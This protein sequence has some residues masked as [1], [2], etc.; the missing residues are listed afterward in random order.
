[1]VLMMPIPALTIPFITSGRSLMDKANVT[2]IAIN[3]ATV[4]R[5]LNQ[6]GNQTD[7][8]PSQLAQLT[9]VINS[10]REHRGSFPPDNTPWLLSLLNH[11]WPESEII[12]LMP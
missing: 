1:M 2:F 7:I 3:S 10:L 4:R 6:F 5:W 9:R 12:H 8:S 11:N